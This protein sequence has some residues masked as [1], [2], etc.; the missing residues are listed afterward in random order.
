MISRNN[1]FVFFVFL[2]SAFS[3]LAFGY[4][5]RL[6]PIDENVAFNLGLNVSSNSLTN[7]STPQILNVDFTFGPHF[8]NNLDA[9][10]YRDHRVLITLANVSSN[11]IIKVK[12]DNN[13]PITASASPSNPNFIDPYI[14]R[15]LMDG[16][17][18][19]T[20]TATVTVS[21]SDNIEI[22]SY[23][24]NFTVGQTSSS[25]E[26]TSIYRTGR[27]GLTYYFAVNFN[28]RVKD[29]DLD[30]VIDGTEVADK[31][32]PL[33]PCSLVLQHQTLQPSNAWMIGDC[34]NDGILNSEVLLVKKLAS[35]VV[36]QPDGSFKFNYTITLRNTRPETLTS[37]YITEDLSKV[38]GSNMS[39]VLEG[40]TVSG[41]LQKNLGYDGQ[42]N[43]NV[44]TS[45][46]T[47]A[48]YASDSI[49]LQVKLQ[50]KGYEG[51]VTN[52]AT[53][54]AVGKWGKVYRES[55][56]TTKSAGRFTGNDVYSQ[57]TSLCLS[58]NG[59]K[60]NLV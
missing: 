39:F 22:T 35:K 9:E 54:N 13:T 3:N 10:K 33:N 52:N 30:G 57:H 6:Y 17:T 28:K 14:P 42:G 40:V 45:L 58:M 20:H 46:S 27:S 50:P 38:F 5:H 36:L 60:I 44:T 25:P 31:T 7:T 59:Q 32:L 34:N 19:G 2:F 8:E 24:K 15:T 41:N 4:P 53:V 47:L 29:T 12:I 16:L 51:Y 18:A 48:G 49:Q 23:S 26:I 55:I 21:S 37:V 43:I 56:D 1:K 11:H